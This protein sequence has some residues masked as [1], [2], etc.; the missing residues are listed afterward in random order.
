MRIVCDRCEGIYEGLLGTKV[1]YGRLMV[2]G[3]C[4]EAHLCDRCGAELREWIAKRK[5][6]GA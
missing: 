2:E 5:E 4:G 1:D 6:T 3:R